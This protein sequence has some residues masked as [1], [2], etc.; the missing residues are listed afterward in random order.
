MGEWV[1]ECR[2][3]QLP[4]HQQT[5]T[6]NKTKLAQT[7]EGS[8]DTP[9]THSAVVRMGAQEYFLFW[10]ER[11]E[12]K[13]RDGKTGTENRMVTGEKKKEDEDQKPGR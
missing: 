5:H 9:R 11:Q 13:E 6:H 7:P 2:R 10:E 3:T 12:K 8:K 4:S 1:E